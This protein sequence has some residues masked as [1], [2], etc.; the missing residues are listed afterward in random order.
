LREF[1]PKVFRRARASMREYHKGG[2]LGGT[3]SRAL[4][5][6]LAL[7]ALVLLPLPLLIGPLGAVASPGLVAASIALDWSTHRAVFADRGVPF[8]CYFVLA[9]LLFQ[10]TAA[11]GAMTGMLQRAL[12]RP[13]AGRPLS[14]QATR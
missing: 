2:E 5:S 11:A 8:G 13:T 7:G 3:P 14:T 12:S 10:T 4:A 9:H 6:A 1:L